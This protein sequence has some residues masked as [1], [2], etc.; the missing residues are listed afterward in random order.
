MTWHIRKV[1]FW[2]DFEQRCIDRAVNGNK[3]IV[4]LC[5]G[6]KTALWTLVTFDTVLYIVPTEILFKRCNFSVHKAA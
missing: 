5:Q 2:A 1:N 4:G 3:T 6:Q